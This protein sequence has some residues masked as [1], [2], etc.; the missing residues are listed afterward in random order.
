MVCV[1][2][3]RVIT[4]VSSGS[5]SQDVLVQQTPGRRWQREEKGWSG[6]R[7]QVCRGAREACQGEP[8]QGRLASDLCVLER[9][10]PST[11]GGWP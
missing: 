8:S 9:L 3:Q 5:H 7:S 2:R 4:E 10:H 1:A 11:D 6:G